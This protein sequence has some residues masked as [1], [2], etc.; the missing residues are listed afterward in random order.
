M[1]KTAAVSVRDKELLCGPWKKTSV[2]PQASLLHPVPTPLGGVVIVGA[3][4]ISYHSQAVQH[5][6]DPPV[7]K[8]DLLSTCLIGWKYCAELNQISTVPIYMYV[9]KGLRVCKVT[10]RL[11]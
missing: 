3:Q 11:V 9:P 7:I 6:I 1:L 5:S 4:T 8:V 2:E 10:C